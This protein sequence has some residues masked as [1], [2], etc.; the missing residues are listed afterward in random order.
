M[1]CSVLMGPSVRKRTLED[2]PC[3]LSILWPFQHYIS[4]NIRGPMEGMMKMTGYCNCKDTQLQ[5]DSIPD[6]YSFIYASLK[7]CLYGL[8][9]A[10]TTKKQMTKFSSKVL[11]PSFIILR[12]CRSR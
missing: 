2:V 8:Y 3:C 10:V 9:R 4:H 1:N 11:S 7:G 12:E 6:H 5:W